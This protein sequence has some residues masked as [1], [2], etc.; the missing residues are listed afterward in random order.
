MPGTSSALYLKSDAIAADG[1]VFG[2]GV[3]C[4]AG[5]LI[6]LRTK[7]N[8]GGAS[9]FPEPG[10]PTVSARGGTPPGSGLTGRYQVYYRNAASGFCPP[11]TFNV[12]NGLSITW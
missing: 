9:R 2:D 11:A 10:D 6:R 4:L 1:V 12:S 3:L 5:G 8:V 7:I